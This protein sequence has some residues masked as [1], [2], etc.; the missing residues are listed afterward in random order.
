MKHHEF[1]SLYARY[2]LTNCVFATCIGSPYPLPTDDDDGDDEETIMPMISLSR[3]NWS[4][5]K[6]EFKNLRDL[7]IRNDTKNTLN[8]FLEDAAVR[9]L[10]NPG[11]VNKQWE[12]EKRFKGSHDRLQKRFEIQEA[13]APIRER[14]EVAVANQSEPSVCQADIDDILYVSTLW[15][16]LSVN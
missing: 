2:L 10:C 6:T 15:V 4:E 12:S 1:G 3:K 13:L 9:K 11:D 14:L 8:F 7:A 5:I 16:A